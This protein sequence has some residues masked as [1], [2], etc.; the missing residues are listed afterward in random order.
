ML[1]PSPRRQLAVPPSDAGASMTD[2][3][4]LVETVRL[5]HGPDTVC[6]Y[7]LGGAVCNCGFEE[8]LTTLETMLNERTEALERIARLDEGW[9]DPD[10]LSSQEVAAFAV[11][12]AQRVLAGEPLDEE[13]DALQGERG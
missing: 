11:R 4:K 10:A 13:P 7:M 5:G 6:N 8:A 1:S 12:W 3:A 2:V 9:S